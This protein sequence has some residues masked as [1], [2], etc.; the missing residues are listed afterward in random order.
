[1]TTAHTQIRPCWLRTNDGTAIQI[2]ESKNIIHLFHSPFL[3]KI[4]GSGICIHHTAAAAAADFQV[5]SPAKK[6]NLVRTPICDVAR[7][8]S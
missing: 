7:D 5:C 6:A 3:L 4:L 2:R 1:M 8:G